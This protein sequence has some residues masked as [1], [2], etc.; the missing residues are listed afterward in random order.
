MAV[1]DRRDLERKLARVLSKDLR[2]ELKKLLDYLGDPPD[3]S[4]VPNEYWRTGWKLIAKH[5]EPILVEYFVEVALEAMNVAQVTIDLAVVST[6]AVEWARNNSEKWLQEAFGKTYE[7]VGELISQSYERGWTYQ[8]LVKALERYYSPVRA[9]MIAVTEMTRAATMA[10]LE[11]EKR[12]FEMTGKHR[13]PIWFTANDEHMCDYCEP[14]NNKPIIDGEY[15][16]AHPRCRCRLAHRSEGLL[17]P[18][19]RA[20]WQSRNSLVEVQQ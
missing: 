13:V 4:R 11:V 5:V 6:G 16:P 20:I 8:E 3:L 14:R 18:E 9:E 17:N 1:F 7:G 19:Q 2:E 15:P 10:E 12:I